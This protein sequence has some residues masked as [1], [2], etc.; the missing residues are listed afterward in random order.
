MSSLVQEIPRN[1][2]MAKAMSQ[3]VSL[4]SFPGKA[5]RQLR[6]APLLG[7]LMQ[8]V[9]GSS[10]CAGGCLSSCQG[11]KKPLQRVL[12]PPLINGIR[13]ALPQ[14]GLRLSTFPQAPFFRVCSLLSGFGKNWGPLC[15]AALYQV[16]AHPS[17]LGMRGDK[18]FRLK[19]KELGLLP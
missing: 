9:G 14:P 13:R 7:D 6:G 2:E 1:L 19:V 5:R 3:R 12:P 8:A 10:S 15:Q 18:M 11:W 4:L 16:Q 17:V